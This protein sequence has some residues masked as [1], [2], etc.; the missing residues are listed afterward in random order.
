MEKGYDLDGRVRRCET[1]D[2]RPIIPLLGPAGV[3]LG[4]HKPPECEHG[5]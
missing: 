1:R 2:V 5:E 4:Q 3:K